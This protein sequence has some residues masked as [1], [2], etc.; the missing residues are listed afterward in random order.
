MQARTQI[1]ILAQAAIHRTRRMLER[2]DS[3]GLQNAVSCGAVLNNRV[4]KVCRTLPGAKILV[5]DS[6]TGIVVVEPEL[7]DN[8]LLKKRALIW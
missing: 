6:E 2:G 3:E 8:L 5:A 7:T 1:E 4:V